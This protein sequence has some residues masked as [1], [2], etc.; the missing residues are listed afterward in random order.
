MMEEEEEEEEGASP[1]D[2]AVVQPL[3]SSHYDVEPAAKVVRLHVH[4]LSAGTGR[5][6]H[7][8]RQ[9]ERNPQTMSAVALDL[10]GVISV[11]RSAASVCSV[12]TLMY[13]VFL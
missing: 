11:S 8:H 10:G 5:S 9:T 4:D 7:R 1:G 13:I 6:S 3:L 12:H 2:A